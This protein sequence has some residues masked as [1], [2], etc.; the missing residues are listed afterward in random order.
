MRQYGGVPFAL[1]AADL[2]DPVQRGFGQLLHSFHSN[3]ELWE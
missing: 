3:H 2:G 1:H